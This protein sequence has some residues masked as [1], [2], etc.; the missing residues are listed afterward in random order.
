MIQQIRR[1]YYRH[2]EKNIHALKYAIA[3]AIGCLI[4]PLLPDKNSVW[5]LITIAVV[6]GSQAIIGQQV[7][8]GAMRMIGTILGAILGILTIYY[9]SNPILIFCILIIAAFFFSKFASSRGTDVTYVAVLGMVTFCL[10]VFTTGANLHYAEMRVIEIFLGIIITLLVSRFIF[11]LN[12]R[13]AVI[14]ECVHEFHYLADFVKKIFI[15]HIDRRSNPDVNQ[16][17]SSIVKS[18][19]KLREIIRSGRYESM[20]PY[21]VKQQF[22]YLIGNLRS[23]YHY[24]LFIDKALY[25]LSA[26]TTQDAENLRDALE[27]AMQILMNLLSQFE[28]EENIKTNKI[29]FENFEFNI[30]DIKSIAITDSEKSQ[31]QLGVIYFSLRQIPICLLKLIESWNGIIHTNQLA[32]E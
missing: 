25:E 10:I 21:R 5:V 12:A 28:V 4:M 9:V 19:I 3:F 14:I 11:P 6:M 26:A 15:E 1:Y 24:L 30:N 7:L 2:Q 20:R 13:R 23:I 8:R 27:P 16:L 17:E 22:N 29:N 31:E 32:K 18:L